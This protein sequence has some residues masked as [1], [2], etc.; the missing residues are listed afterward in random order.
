MRKAPRCDLRGALISRGWALLAALLVASPVGAQSQI[1]A[2]T[3]RTWHSVMY[4]SVLSAE[5]SPDGRQVAFLRTNPRRPLADDSGPS[6]V[7]LYLLDAEGREVPFVTGKVNV[8]GVTWTDNDRLAFLARREGDDHRSVYQ[9]STRGGE[10]RK[11]FEHESD[12]VSF[13]LSPDGRWLAFLARDEKSRDRTMLEDKGFNQEIFEEDLLFTRMR[14]ADL[15]SGDGPG[16]RDVKTLD[17][18]GSLRSVQF[19]PDGQRLLVATTPT[20][21]VDDS[22]VAKRLRVLDLDGKVM[23]RIES[24]GKLGR[25]AWSPDGRHIAM[26]S[27]ADRN[28]PAPGRLVAMAADGGE[29]RDLLPGLEGHVADFDWLDAGTLVWVADIGTRTE[30]GAVSIAGRN[31]R[32]LLLAGSLIVS[33]LDVGDNGMVALIA[34]SPKHP[35][36]LYTL[37][38]TGGTADR[39]TSSNRWLADL[40]LANQEAIRFKARD[41]LELDGILI[42]P[43]EY[44]KNQRYPL[45]MVVHGGPESHYRNG[46]LTGYSSPGQV[47]AAR[48]FAVFY[49]NYRGSTGRGVA[50]SKM[51]QAAAAGAEFDDLVDGV[52]HL[53]AIGLADRNKVGITG[54]SYGGYASAWGAT[55]YSD[56]FAAAIPFVGISDAISKVGT[57][58]IPH[59]MYDS[60][61]RKWLWE[62]WDYFAKAS[63]ISYVKRNET[64]TLI[65]HGKEDP[66]VHPSQSLE[67]YR[68]LK[69]LGQAP[70][71]L[72]FYPGE[73]HG[74]RRSAARLDYALRTLR[75]MEHYLK[76]PAGDAPNAEIDYA[77]H[78]PW[79][80]GE[81]SENDGKTRTDTG[82]GATTSR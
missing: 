11:L 20:P 48:G 43:L 57:T 45:I 50:F 30:V 55:Y 32:T 16:D 66:R 35:N 36:E 25:V 51:S 68:H 63:P 62:D 78:L 15:R 61:H 18:E 24:D 82:S 41:G 54:G 26:V 47:A 44:Q 28:D 5:V 13:D 70:V 19:S 10:A 1:A 14:L 67:L 69:V 52:D 37:T 77:R 8:A 56:R 40:R 53:I 65:L 73:G 27:A 64:S 38:P 34:Q 74:N 23:A 79:P 46:W 4:R 29:V 72:V 7:E 21:L 49:P 39:R 6:W 76:G 9:I 60:H 3:F 12:V 58:D 42:Y 59:E 75:W 22:Y 2:D 33:R 31:R 80:V 81:E 17:V 71:R